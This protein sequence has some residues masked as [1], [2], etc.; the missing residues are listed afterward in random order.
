MSDDVAVDLSDSGL[1]DNTPELVYL[2]FI[3]YLIYN[4]MGNMKTLWCFRCFL[5]YE[6]VKLRN[7][8]PIGKW[9]IEQVSAWYEILRQNSNQKKEQRA[10]M[11]KFMNYDD[12]NQLFYCRGFIDTWMDD[13]KR[14]ETLGGSALVGGK[15]KTYLEKSNK[16]LIG[17]VR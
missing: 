7:K 3:W 10:T 14:E 2:A 5:F 11:D 12:V 13:S 17:V 4:S 1:R 8:V 6:S 16:S 9:V 15:Y